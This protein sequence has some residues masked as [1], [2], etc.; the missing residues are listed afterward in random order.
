[1]IHLIKPFVANITFHTT[2][3]IETAY[4]K[5]V[6]P[7]HEKIIQLPN[8]IQISE[9]SPVTKENYFLI[10]G[11][12]DRKKGIENAI[13]AC[14][15]STKFMRSD[16]KL[17][18][19]GDRNNAYGAELEDLVSKNK[20]EHKVE[21]IDH[22]SIISVKNKIFSQAYFTLLPSHT[23][24]FGNVVVES[25]MH[26][27]PVLASKGTPWEILSRSGAGFWVCNS[28]E[29]IKATIDKIFELSLFEYQHMCSSARALSV[30][31]FGI[32]KNIYKWIQVLQTNSCAK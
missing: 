1:M 3:N 23:E 22:I 29:S 30:D 28:V 18:I 5:R 10:I 8:Y 26:G 9:R 21:F 32:K 25:L 24:N 4:L 2:S 12:I 15:N 14:L 19:V 31:E 11:R 17:K 16:F 6:F 7:K 27:T 20:A 13:S